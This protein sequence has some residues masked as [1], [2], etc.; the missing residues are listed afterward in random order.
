M[1]GYN[2]DSQ[3]VCLAYL[4]CFL[5]LSFFARTHSLFLSGTRSFLFARCLQ[6]LPAHKKW[7]I[8]SSVPW[9]EL[10]AW[11]N[12]P[13]VSKHHRVRLVRV[14]EVCA[15]ALWINLMLGVLHSR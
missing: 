1:T 14:H 3:T 15:E 11:D 13:G 12:S 5:L 9:V 2:S 4:P 10:G 6:K 7:L 8:R